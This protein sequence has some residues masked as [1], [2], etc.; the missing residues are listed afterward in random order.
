MSPNAQAKEAAGQRTTSSAPADISGEYEAGSTVIQDGMDVVDAQGEHLG[1]VTG[2][3]GSDFLL[4]RPHKRDLYVPFGTA[5]AVPGT[6]RVELNVLA[7]QIDTLG[8]ASPP[9]V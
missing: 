4:A 7:D 8:W 5:R 3:R 6:N 9:L 1:V 2:V